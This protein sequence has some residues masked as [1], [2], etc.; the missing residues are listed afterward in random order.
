MASPGRPK[1]EKPVTSK[2]WETRDNPWVFDVFKL[3]KVHNGFHCVFVGKGET[4]TFFQ[5]GYAFAKPSDYGIIN[6]EESE[7]GIAD[8]VYR[9]GTVL[10]EISDALFK[11]RADYFREIT[12]KQLR[13]AK[14]EAET[15]NVSGAVYIDKSRTTVR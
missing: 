14:D 12:D 13:D 9:K 4:D 11:Q 3:N 7:K 1:T 2:P 15:G 5:K 6:S 8:R 10:M